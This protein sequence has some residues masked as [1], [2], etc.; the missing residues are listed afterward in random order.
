MLSLLAIHFLLRLALIIRSARL[1]TACQSVVVSSPHIQVLAQE[2][3]GPK[4][5]DKGIANGLIIQLIQRKICQNLQIVEC[6]RKNFMIVF[7]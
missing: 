3:Y 4:V 1:C 7:T 5:N 6:A 2:L